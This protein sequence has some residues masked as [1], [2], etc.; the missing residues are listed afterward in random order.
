MNRITVAVGDIHGCF[1]EFNELLKTIQYNPNQMRL[2]LLGD[3]MDRGPAQAELV[4]KVREMGIECVLGNHEEKHIRWRKHELVRQQTGES[5]PMKPLSELDASE[6]SKLS[7][8]DLKWMKRLP[9]K[10]DLGNN[11]WAVHAGVEPGV[12]FDSQITSQIIRVRYVN[13]AG[14][15]VSSNPDHSQPPNTTYWSRIWSGP[16]S[17]IYGHCIWSLTDIRKDD[18]PNGVVCRGLDTG[19]VFGGH[20]TAMLFDPSVSNSETFV[21]VKAKKQYYSG[22]GEGLQD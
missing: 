16:Q 6:H 21:K 5:N 15:G 9:A 4:S 13:Q 2:V 11:W 7:D 17:I 22:F 10:I 3:L 12:P 18:H 1:E 19:C 14:R 20:L 8:D